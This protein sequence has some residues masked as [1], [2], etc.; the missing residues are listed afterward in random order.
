MKFKLIIFMCF[1]S[2]LSVTSFAKV[3]DSFWC[4]KISAKF[5]TIN[6]DDF[7]FVEDKSSDNP[8]SM[9]ITILED[10]YLSFDNKH[11]TFKSK[12]KKGK[13]GLD[14]YYSV[15]EDFPYLGFYLLTESFDA[16]L[17]KKI[18]G[19]YYLLNYKIMRESTQL[20]KYNCSKR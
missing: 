13:E 11:G 6:G 1:F 8:N 16:L 18:E 7:D 20:I 3:G 10:N 12:W 2:F 4:T 15:D 5:S 14:Q 9:S 19:R 17:Q